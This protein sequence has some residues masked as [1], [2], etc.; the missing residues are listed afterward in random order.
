M[1]QKLGSAEVLFHRPQRRKQTHFTFLVVVL[2]VSVHMA[3]DWLVENSF[4]I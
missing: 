3:V 4:E 2:M 1:D